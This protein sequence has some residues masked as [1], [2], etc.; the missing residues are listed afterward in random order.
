MTKSAL[1]LMLRSIRPHWYM[2]G[3]Q[4]SGKVIAIDGVQYIDSP[5]GFR[6]VARVR[7]GKIGA[8]SDFKPK[9]PKR[10]PRIARGR[11]VA[12]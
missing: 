10:R 4:K 3:V 11:K 1:T 6:K 2:H 5:Q 9:L 7:M 12:R 8:G